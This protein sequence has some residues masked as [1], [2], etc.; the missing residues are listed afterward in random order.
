MKQN[1][2]FKDKLGQLLK[3]IRLKKRLSQQQVADEGKIARSYI[4]R[5]EGGYVKSISLLTIFRFAKGLK[6]PSPELFKLI[7]KRCGEFDIIEDY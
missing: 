3:E 1:K 5:I 4:S 7:I 6:I 2:T